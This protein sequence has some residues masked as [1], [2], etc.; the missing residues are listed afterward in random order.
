MTS[1]TNR[2]GDSSKL[3]HVLFGYSQLSLDEREACRRE[4][5]A[6]NR[7]SGSERV[8]KK[9]QFADE[10]RATKMDLGPVGRSCPCCGR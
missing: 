9:Q 4:I 5:L 1:P 2:G 7:A 6:F 10:R 3:A 8:S